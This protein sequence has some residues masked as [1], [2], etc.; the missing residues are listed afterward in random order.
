M[1]SVSVTLEDI[2]GAEKFCTRELSKLKNSVSGL[3]NS[4]SNSS[5]WND[6]KFVAID[7]IV[8]QAVA[9]LEDSIN[10][11]EECIK[12]LNALKKEVEN[13]ESTKF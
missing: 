10:G 6:E 3:K 5:G 4:V 13:Y 2:I 11:L 12:N 1:Y 8:N 9:L 7:N